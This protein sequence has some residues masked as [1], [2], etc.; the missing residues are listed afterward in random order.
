MCGHNW[1]FICNSNFDFQHLLVYWATPLVGAAVAS[2]LHQYITRSQTYHE[3]KVLKI[4]KKNDIFNLYHYLHKSGYQGSV[5]A[6]N[7]YISNQA[8]WVNPEEEEVK[9]SKAG[10]QSSWQINIIREAS[11]I[12]LHW[13]EN[14]GKPDLQPKKR[15]VAWCKSSSTALWTTSYHCLLYKVHK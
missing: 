10:E 15:I 12:T 11:Y 4:M 3:H 6:N 1:E 8:I 14:R 5:P 13:T 2:A 7:D 9:C